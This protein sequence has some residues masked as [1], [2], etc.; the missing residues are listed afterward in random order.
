MAIM[1]WCVSRILNKVLY[2]HKELINKKERK[3]ISYLMVSEATYHI[4]KSY[5][6]RISLCFNYLHEVL[7]H[8][9]NDTEGR[10]NA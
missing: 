2:A 3:N 4:K 7:K 10:D 5:D 1:P 8:M 6:F 9:A